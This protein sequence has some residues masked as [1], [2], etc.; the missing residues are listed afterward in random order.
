[1]NFIKKESKLA[2]LFANKNSQENNIISYIIDKLLDSDYY[3]NKY[4]APINDHL[5]EIL[6]YYKNYLIKSNINEI[7][8]NEKEKKIDYFKSNEMAKYMNNRLPLILY[9]F[10]IKLE[11]EKLNISEKDIIQK[12]KTYE[13]LERII[14]DKKYKKM[15]FDFKR[16]LLNYF[17][18]ESNKRV[19]TTIFKEEDYQD[20]I[21]ANIGILSNK[22]KKSKK[23]KQKGYELKDRNDINEK[24][25]LEGIS[26]LIASSKDKTFLKVSPSKSKNIN[27]SDDLLIEESSVIV[28]SIYFQDSSSMINFNV[29]GG[30][31]KTELTEIEK[32]NEETDNFLNID[33]DYID[34]GKNLFK[35]SSKYKIVEVNKKIGNHQMSDIVKSIGKGRYLSAGTNRK[36]RIYDEYFEKKLEIDMVD[37]V[38]DIIE[39]ES[40]NETEIRLLSCCN[41]YTFYFIINSEN[42]KYK[43]FKYK[44]VSISSKSILKSENSFIIMGD[45][46]IYNIHNIFE[47]NNDYIQRYQISKSNFRGGTKINEY[48]YAFTSN[49]ILPNGEDFLIIYNTRSKIIVKSIEKYSFIVSS[50][51]LCLIDTNINKNNKILLCACRKYNSGQKNGILL[52]ELQLNNNNNKYQEFFYDTECFQVNCFCQICDVKNENAMGDDITKKENIKIKKTNFVLVGGY[53]EDRGEG[54]IKLYEI[55]ENKLK[56]LQDIEFEFDENFK[57][58]DNSVSC[59]TQSNITGNILVTCWDGNVYLLNPPN[60]DFYLKNKN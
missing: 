11:K 34:K 38:Y 50:N 25:K 31:N 33:N 24:K 13:S 18:D 49:S 8:I 36:M 29:N 59:I 58:F 42:F 53:D 1:M 37:W 23:G 20:F 39:I 35:K 14:K 21:K 48:L 17:I 40:D 2:L 3:N 32:G 56:F 12:L 19:L 47:K 51:G 44:I 43:Y 45:A 60:I 46:G 9:L 22:E 4:M 26:N 55:K 54:V 57:G 52:I 15:R 6:Y 10:D 41:N 16:K 28:Q 5:K 27:I 30:G 7:N